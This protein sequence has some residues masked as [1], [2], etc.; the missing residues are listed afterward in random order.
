ML[1]HHFFKNIFILCFYSSLPLWKQCIHC[2]KHK[3]T[4]F[5]IFS[6]TFGFIA[7]SCLSVFPWSSSV[8]S[9]CCVSLVMPL[10]FV[11]KQ[12]PVGWPLQPLAG[13]S[14]TMS[15]PYLHSQPTK[16][17]LSASTS[18]FVCLGIVKYVQCLCIEDMSS[19]FKIVVGFSLC[20]HHWY[21]VWDKSL[22]LLDITIPLYGGG[23]EADMDTYEWN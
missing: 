16:F 6:S 3:N 15:T 21:P 19:S 17:S 12:R 7:I 18:V 9:H 8:L 20:S 10:T 2:T 22:F 1:Q 23:H 4:A 14:F 5:I 13:F 11:S